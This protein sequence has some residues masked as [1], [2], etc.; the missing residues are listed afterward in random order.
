MPANRPSYSTPPGEDEGGGR[1]QAK[2]WTG[3]LEEE[4]RKGAGDEPRD[5][6][7]RTS[8]SRPLMESSQEQ[9]IIFQQSG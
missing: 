1:E 8:V 3:E 6:D 4:E 9:V 2:R 7:N 5:R